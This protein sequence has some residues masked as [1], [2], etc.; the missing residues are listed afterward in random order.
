[1]KGFLLT[2]MVDLLVISGM[3][4]S[5]F[6]FHILKFYHL[7]NSSLVQLLELVA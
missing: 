2:F 1:M 3:Q 5:L 4:L 7:D 6:S